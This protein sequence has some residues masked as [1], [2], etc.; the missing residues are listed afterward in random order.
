MSI[1]TSYHDAIT[2]KSCNFAFRRSSPSLV[3]QRS[4]VDM[5]L[6]FH[7]WSSAAFKA[8]IKDVCLCAQQVCGVKMT[9]RLPH[10][11]LPWAGGGGGGGGSEGCVGC[12]GLWSVVSGDICSEITD[13]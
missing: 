9:W 2:A 6:R 7:I 10:V 3:V 11:H 4:R 8:R 13:L 1:P 5:S 12:I